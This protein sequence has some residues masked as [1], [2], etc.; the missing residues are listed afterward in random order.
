MASRIS[1]VIAN[2]NF[3][4]QVQQSRIASRETVDAWIQQTAEP[5]EETPMGRLRGFPDIGELERDGER[6]DPFCGPLVEEAVPD[7]PP[8]I[9][10]CL[11]PPPPESPPFPAG[12]EEAVVLLEGRPSLLIRGD[13]VEI[14]RS[15]VWAQPLFSARALIEPRLRSVGRIE[16]DSGAGARH[17]GTGWMVSRGVIA[18][19]RHV[20]EAFAA[21]RSGKVVFLKNHL[22][23][24]YSAR[25]DFLEEYQ[26][27]QQF[28]VRIKSILFLQEHDLQKPDVALLQLEDQV[29]LP[30]PIPILS[31]GPA[32]DA[33]IAVIGYP[34]Y[35]DRY[36]ADAQE[37]AR[38][39]FGSIYNVKR[40]SPGLVM[41][42][43]PGCWYFTHDATTLGGCSGSLVLDLQSGMAVG[44]H[45]LGDFRNANY[46]VHAEVVAAIAEAQRKNIVRLS[47]WTP[48]PVSGGEKLEK[49]SADSYADREGYSRDFIRHEKTLPLP[50]PA[51]GMQA[52]ILKWGPDR[53]RDEL[54]YTHFSVVMHAERRLC[55]FSAVNI[56]GKKSVSVKGRRPSWRLDPRIPDDA[57]ILK[58]C[59]GRESDGKFSRGHM[60]RR[61]DPNWGKAQTVKRANADTFHVTNA[62]PQMQPFN[63]GI[64]NGLEDYAL[65]NARQDDMRISVFTGPVFR[66]DDPEL[67]ETKVKIPVTFWKVIAFI[68]DDT[69]KLTATGYTMSQRDF[70]PGEEFVYGQFGTY[71]TSLREIEQATGLSFGILT[72]CDPMKELPETPSMALRPLRGYEEIVYIPAG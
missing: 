18:T 27:P 48:A 9:A 65:Q 35:D 21:N 19:N 67:F 52:D 32:P 12:K 63:A 13:R 3:Q 33:R 53:D 34:A 22:G 14:P 17:G 16:I 61:E 62:C 4:R 46:A 50:R 7:G 56:D 6:L 1:S 72:D 37:I 42:V 28:E 57:Q 41:E 24:D 11:V 30:P 23:S 60:T 51:D 5:A 10:P 39:I 45:F 44:M 29:S 8:S 43:S 26:E 2:R 71:Q 68:H 59:Y 20:A 38:S 64:W 54:K 66:D 25:I 49:A 47:G 70:L 36:G 55:I 15:G 69:G 31:G 58:E 40:L